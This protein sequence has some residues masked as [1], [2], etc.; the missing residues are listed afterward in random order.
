MGRH[1]VAAPPLD[2]SDHGFEAIIGE[3]LDLAAAVADKVVMV[4]V[5][6][7]HRLETGHAVAEVETL[8]KALLGER[9]EDAVDARQ[10]YRLAALAQSIVY[11]LGADTAGLGIEERDHGQPRRT[12]PVAGGS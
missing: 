9:V 4:V 2:V 5:A 10:P 3:R 11:L 12:A 6:G 1:L 7:P 8:E